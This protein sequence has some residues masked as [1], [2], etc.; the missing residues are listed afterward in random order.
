MFLSNI[1]SIVIS[2]SF[3]NCIALLV[4]KKEIN[5]QTYEVMEEY[6]I[7]GQHWE[8]EKRGLTVQ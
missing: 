3:M 7:F 6:L 4:K 8:Y 5:T 1:A 2:V